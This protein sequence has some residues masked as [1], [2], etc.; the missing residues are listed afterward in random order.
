MDSLLKNK[1]DSFR[2]HDIIPTEDKQHNVSG[3]IA[4]FILEDDLCN[5]KASVYTLCF[6]RCVVCTLSLLL[7]N[8]CMAQLV[9]FL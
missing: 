8:L 4:W 3:T 6:H 5:C 9:H 2:V 7:L 1:T